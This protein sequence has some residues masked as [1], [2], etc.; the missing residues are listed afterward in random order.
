MSRERIWAE[1]PTSTP[2]VGCATM[3]TL[4]AASISRADDELLQIAPGQ[5]ARHGLGTARRHVV[6]R[7]QS[8][9][10]CAQQTGVCTNPTSTPAPERVS[11]VFFGERQARH[12]GTAEPLVRHEAQ[13]VLAPLREGPSRVTSSSQS[14]M[15]PEA[16]PTSS[17]ESAAS[18]SCCPLPETPATP[19]ISPPRT[20]NVTSRRV[21][22]NSWL[23][24][25]F[26]LSTVR[27]ASRGSL[28]SSLDA[29]WLVAEHQTRE[30]GGRFLTRVGLAHDSTGAEHGRR[31][32]QRLDLVE[33]VA[34]VEDRAA[35]GRELA[36]RREQRLARPAE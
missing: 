11:S 13:A 12:G 24:S 10:Q 34:D 33:L 29:R 15:T 19:R 18:N 7:E 6:A 32:A 30:R 8:S 16:R 2:Q 3:R 25:M 17:P 4:G 28:G 23:F 5:A 27:L 21:T 26:R 20:P 36:Q 31:V 14:R 9:C 22:P 35:L 1:A